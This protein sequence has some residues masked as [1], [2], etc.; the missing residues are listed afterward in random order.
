MAIKR[1][2]FEI[3]DC[4]ILLEASLNSRA[5][6]LFPEAFKPSNLDAPIFRGHGVERFRK[7]VRG[8]HGP[9]S[10]HGRRGRFQG[11]FRLRAKVFALGDPQTPARSPGSG[12]SQGGS[13]P[14][15]ER[16]LE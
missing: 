3:I 1:I 6:S 9:G 16:H 4:Q 12:A 8:Q 15:D 13:G 14:E 11:G 10:D 7:R 2:L 5:S